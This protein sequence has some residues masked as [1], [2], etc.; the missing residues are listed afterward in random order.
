MV[1]QLVELYNSTGFFNKQTYIN[2][3]NQI[4]V[5]VLQD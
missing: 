3:V 2:P 5:T 4:F 1:K